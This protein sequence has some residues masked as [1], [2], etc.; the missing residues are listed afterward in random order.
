MATI[1]STLAPVIPSYTPTKVSPSFSSIINEYYSPVTYLNAGGNTLLASDVIGGF[2]IHT[3]AGA[4]TDTLP[5][6]TL[7]VQAIQGCRA[8]VPGAPA[9]AVGVAGSGIRFFVRSGGAGAITLA[10]GAGGTLVGSGLGVT[11]IASEYLLIITST[12]DVNNVGAT[13][14]VYAIA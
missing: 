4:Q 10:V 8:S 12:G 1:P 14:T 6:A 5:T 9:S 13:Y 7:M 3:A 2:I 11:L